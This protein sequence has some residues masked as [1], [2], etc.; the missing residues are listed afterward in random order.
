MMKMSMRNHTWVYGV[1]HTF[2][3]HL[4]RFEERIR[5]SCATRDE[6]HDVTQ[7]LSRKDT[8][9]IHHVHNRRSR[10]LN[11]LALWIRWKTGHP[12]ALAMMFSQSIQ[13]GGA[14]H[15]VKGMHVNVELQ[16]F[17][18]SCPW[19]FNSI[20]RSTSRSHRNSVTHR[21]VI[22]ISALTMENPGV[23]LQVYDLIA[24]H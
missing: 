20:A 9:L 13:H 14:T 8:S 22:G 2:A 17:Q 6:G 16:H 3:K 12:L 24:P 10:L 21:S 4:Y 19:T 1:S 15:D 5:E 18:S 7:L 23:L 11:C